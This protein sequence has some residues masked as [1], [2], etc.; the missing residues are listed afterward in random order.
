MP[1]LNPNLNSEVLTRVQT[2]YQLRR[3]SRPAVVKSVGLLALIS[4]TALQVSVLNV[5]A[6][7]PSPADP[8]AMYSFAYSAIYNTGWLVRLTTFGL[9]FVL[10]W[11]LGDAWR[12]IKI[13]R[14]VPTLPRFSLNLFRF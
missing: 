7:S 3:L 1:N 6:N 12:N 8:K 9:M 10:G 11:L 14:F 13:S 5:I 2:V 4:A